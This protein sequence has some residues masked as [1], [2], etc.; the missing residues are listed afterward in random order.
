M[1]VLAVG[2]IFGFGVST[3]WWTGTVSALRERVSLYQDRLQGASPDQAAQKI[4][5]LTEQVEAL[6]SKERARAAKEWPPLTPKQIA[7]WAIRLS[8]Y[9][10]SFLAVFFTDGNSEAFRESL[11][12]MFR[13]ASW[14]NPTVLNAGNDIGIRI[15]A[16]E[17]DPIATEFFQ[18]LDEL[19]MQKAYQHENPP[20]PGKLQIY[21]GKL[22]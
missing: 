22:N 12:E 19:P 16:A 4:K 2:I 15:L 20:T 9:K 10:P 3:L 7:K 17:N 5:T 21:I 6:Q 18:L 1:I 13:E 11:Y 8:K 14:Q